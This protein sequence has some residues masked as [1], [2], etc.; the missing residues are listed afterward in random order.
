M[1]RERRSAPNSFIQ[2]RY[3]LRDAN[4]SFGDAKVCAVRAN[5]A[6]AYVLCSIIVRNNSLGLLRKVY[7]CSA[8]HHL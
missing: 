4:I 6:N 5:S 3:E 1:R 2:E 8:V 7:F